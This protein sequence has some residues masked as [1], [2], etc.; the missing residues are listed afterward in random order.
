M[1][2]E[3]GPSLKQRG[4]FVSAANR[5]VNLSTD[6]ATGS[7]GGG[8]CEQL[9]DGGSGEVPLVAVEE[10]CRDVGEYFTRKVGSEKALERARRLISSPLRGQASAVGGS[11]GGQ[12]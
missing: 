6:Q 11:P 1:V 3:A 7:A 4:T 2:E 5:G 12:I 10:A 9:H 8:D